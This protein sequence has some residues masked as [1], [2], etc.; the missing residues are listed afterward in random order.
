MNTLRLVLVILFSGVIALSMNGQVSEKKLAKFKKKYR[1][2]QSYDK[3]YITYKKHKA[4]FAN[5]KLKSIIK[6]K[7]DI[8]FY[9]EDHHHV[10]TGMEGQSFND[11]GGKIVNG[12]DELQI[13]DL[14]TKVARPIL[15]NYF[16]FHRSYS[17]L[18]NT[19][20][21]KS[22]PVVKNKITGKLNVID[23]NG[24]LLLAKDYDEIK[25]IKGDT[26]VY[27][28]TKLSKTEFSYD[29][30]DVNGDVLYRSKNNFGYN[31]S[32]AIRLFANSKYGL[33]I[34]ENNQFNII[35]FETKNEMLDK[36]Y[37]SIEFLK[38][39]YNKD[40]V[41]WIFQLTDSINQTSMF[42]P[43]APKMLISDFD[44]EVSYSNKKYRNEA[45]DKRMF[46]CVNEAGLYNYFVVSTEKFLFPI[47]VLNDMSINDYR[48]LNL[49]VTEENGTRLYGIYNE[50]EGIYFIEMSDVKIKKEQHYSIK[51]KKGGF[52]YTYMENGKK[53]RVKF[54]MPKKH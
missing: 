41:L 30:L 19:V 20:D 36:N 42:D 48:H 45:A 9:N 43:L 53:L 51:E 15:E 40:K 50:E 21:G 38:T 31:P 44:I 25:S 29:I 17:S 1:V 39:G 4:G 3:G 14:D 32:G 27:G 13:I 37:S 16:I 34:H 22:Y 49:L 8:L 23:S 54:D 47:W 26:K 33:T 24:D 5:R 52:V 35:D 6:P 10:L 46:K 18:K 28:I 11:G 12:Y 7:Y 2:T